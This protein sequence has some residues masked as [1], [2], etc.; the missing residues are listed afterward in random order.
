M[1][2][3]RT[4]LL[5]VAYGRNLLAAAQQKMFSNAAAIIEV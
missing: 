1:Y 2:K 3:V 4:V 5:N